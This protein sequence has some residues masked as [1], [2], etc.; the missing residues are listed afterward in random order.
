[1]GV[2]ATS[3]NIMNAIATNPL[4]QATAWTWRNG[5]ANTRTY[6]VFGR[7]ST[8]FLGNPSGSGIAS[9]LRR[10]VGYDAAGKPISFTHSNAVGAQPAFD[11][12]YAY[13]GRFRLI[14]ATIAGTPYGYAYDLTDNRIDLVA[15]GSDL[16][17]TISASSNR[18][19][20]AQLPGLVTLAFTYDANGNILTD[21]T[22]TYRYSARGR[23]SSVSTA[24]S[25]VNYLY[26]AMEQRAVKSGTP[27]PTGAAYFVYDESGSLLGEYDANGI[28][29][30][31][32]VYLAGAPVAVLKTTGTAAASNLAVSTYHAYTD[33]LGTPRVVTR[34]SDEAIVWRW[35]ASDAFGSSAPNQNPSGL[36]TFVL[37]QRFPG[38]VFDAETGLIQNWNREY[39]PRIGRYVETDPIGL[40]GGLN[41][42]AYVLGNP[43]SYVDP[44]G[45]ATYVAN[46]NFSAIGSSPQPWWN[47][48]SH[49]YTFSTNPDGS[50]AATYSWGNE[51]NL[52]G[53]NL[54][55]PEDMKAAADALKNGDARTVGPDFMDPYYRKAFDELKDPKNEHSNGILSNN[56][57]TEAEKLNNRAW[58]LWKK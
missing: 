24:G 47:T 16:V 21:G 40:K 23:L 41:T 8:Y 13:D 27:V 36:G 31:E 45:L 52:T 54:N 7:I 57:K 5:I 26:N 15:D 4:G 11:H 34:S 37:N 42:Y 39:N 9:G 55:Q 43:L 32:S 35:D 12:A 1:V 50:I 58:D 56:C 22:N 46:R 30:Y 28:P 49:T 51:A 48:V 33:H 44:M 38:Q 17:Q 3:V 6:D 10:T 2:S 53:W 14:D 25:T 19:T 20:G 29:V 18:I